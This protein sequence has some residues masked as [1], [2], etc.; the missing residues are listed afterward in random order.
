M[1]AS[2][3]RR[4][5]DEQT[6]FHLIALNEQ[7]EA[8][9]SHPDNSRF[10]SRSPTCGRSGLE[11]GY[12]VPSISRGGVIT[13]MGR[14]ADLI[15]NHAEDEDKNPPF[16]SAR[17][18]DFELQ[19]HSRVVMLRVVS[20]DERSVSVTLQS[21]ED[22][23]VD[24]I[25]ISGVEAPERHTRSEDWGDCV[26]LYNR[27]Y[28]ITICDYKFNLVWVR[29]SCGELEALALRGWEISD[30]KAKKL[31]AR[32]RPTPK[33]PLYY[34]RNRP[35]DKPECPIRET[36]DSRELKHESHFATVHKAL[37]NSYGNNIIVVTVKLSK[38]GVQR[39]DEVRTAI[40][41]EVTFLKNTD[42][43]VFLYLLL[44]N[45][46]TTRG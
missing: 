10:I 9:V 22:T 4:L 36:A 34:I 16:V 26:L 27:S 5:P 1:A 44:P 18:V 42:T 32:E 24:D 23:D 12:H 25:D 31:P 2:N 33:D 41:R 35:V 37:D 13:S 15:L 40:H 28:L 29:K 17:H 6:L 19:R 14:R 20:T 38:F 46:Q 45:R 21:S 3:D 11:V 8:A 39:K 30:A 7:A 43:L